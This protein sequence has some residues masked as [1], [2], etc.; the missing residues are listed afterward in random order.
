MNISD[1][2]TS[3][4]DKLFNQAWELADFITNHPEIGGE[5]EQAVAKLTEFLKKHGYSIISPY[6]GMVHSFLAADLSD[7]SKGKPKV[8][9][10]CEYDALPEIGHACGH[11]IHGVI[12]A[13]AAVALRDAFQDF[14][15]RLDVIGTPNEEAYGG[16]VFMAKNGAFNGY[17]FAIMGHIDNINCPQIK[18]IACDGFYVSFKGVSTHASSSP[19]L[20]VNAL[21]AAQFFMHASDML[22][23][24]LTPDCQIHGIVAYGGEAPNITP[25]RIDLDYYYRAATME[26]MINLK[27]KL[28]DC[29]KGAAVA[30]GCSYSLKEN[31]SELFAELS[32]LPTAVKAVCDTFDALGM[33]WQEMAGPEGSTDA[34]NV[35]LCIP[36]FHIELNGTDKFCG[37]HTREFE[38]E[39]HGA[40]GQKTLLNGTQVIAQYINYLAQNLDLLTQ[41]KKEHKAYR[42]PHTS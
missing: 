15:F 12:S 30:T 23:Q 20:G 5:E 37:F 19:Q 42:S 27:S 1:A 25:D 4:I 34:G 38:A 3:S 26:H 10:M 24:H 35:D 16:K 14:P 41:I 32:Y 7:K 22:R 13:L 8:A 6:C 11:S 31:H 17:E 33:P 40:R 9:L 39:M 18:V 21:N 36:T 29:I 2:L 28:M